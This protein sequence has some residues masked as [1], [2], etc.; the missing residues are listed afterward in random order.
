MGAQN[1]PSAIVDTELAKDLVVVPL[2]V[3]QRENDAVSNFLITQTLR[4]QR[5]DFLFTLSDTMGFGRVNV[6]HKFFG[7]HRIITIWTPIVIQ[8]PY[9][10][11]YFSW[12]TALLA[13]E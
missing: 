1:S 13:K 10:G 8:I 4:E 9:C 6:T 12:V 11:Y 3:G 2:D 7:V 5:E